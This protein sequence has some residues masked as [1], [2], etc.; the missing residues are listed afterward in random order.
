MIEIIEYIEAI[1]GRTISDEML[2]TLINMLEELD[3]DP[4]AQETIHI[5]RGRIDTLEEEIEDIE[6]RP[7]YMCRDGMII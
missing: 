6:S 3:Y 7:L 4:K 2:D 1:K 5:L